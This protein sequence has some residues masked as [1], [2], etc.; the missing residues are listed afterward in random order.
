MK[1]AYL[2]ID[3]EPKTKAY[4]VA[5]MLRCKP[6]ISFADVV[7]GPHDVIAVLNG[8]DSK[9]CQGF[10]TVSDIREIE[11]VKYITACL[12]IRT[13]FGND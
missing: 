10:K 2:L 7:T 1:N 8:W 11:G 9:G 13:E 6:C 12:A 3:I 4:Q 5:S